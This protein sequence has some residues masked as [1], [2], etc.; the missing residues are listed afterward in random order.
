VRAVNLKGSCHFD[1]CP[2]A[3]SRCNMGRVSRPDRYVC[4]RLHCGSKPKMLAVCSAVR[5]DAIGPGCVKTK[6][7]LVVMP[8]GGR[9]FVF[10][11][12]AHDPRAQNS[13][14]GYTA[15]SFHTA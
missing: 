12:S 2:T 8:S 10:F 15:S 6:S 9:I 13:R 11:R 14:C 3:S 7:D 5:N 1:R 4:D